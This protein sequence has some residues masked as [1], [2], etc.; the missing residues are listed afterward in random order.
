[1]KLDELE[2]NL[3]RAAQ[4]ELS[5]SA[6]DRERTRTEL[7]ARLGGGGSSGG[8][9]APLR[10]AGSVGSAAS[11]EAASGATGVGSSG[12]GSSRA[13]PWSS[14][15]LS[16]LERSPAVLS[17]VA[18]SARGSR[19]G[20][21]GLGLI[22][23]AMVGGW[24]GFGLGQSGWNAAREREAEREAA[25]SASG[26]NAAREREAE[27]EAAQSA[28]PAPPSAVIVG[29]R[30]VGGRV[31]SGPVALLATEEAPRDLTTDAVAAVLPGQSLAPP[32][33]DPNG[34]R[35]Q[36][37][38]P[39]GAQAARRKSAVDEPSSLAAEVAMLQ[40]ARRALNSENGR[41]A[42]GIVQD[43]DA[44]FPRGILIEERNATRVL[45]LCQLDRADEARQVAQAF[46]ERYPASVYAER[47]RGSCIAHAEE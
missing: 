3:I 46:L 37:S 40:R 1:V 45:S 43:L 31:A 15:A 7:F 21:L 10:S 19:L 17:R 18:A 29:G 11:S 36:G 8:S 41:L 47:V 4:R 23:G 28:L 38:T 34:G 16:N 14:A 5:P 13:A 42:L 20:M 27:R 24:F 2:R 12:V 9:G 22:V 30:V 39:R 32:R 26:W 35:A 25:Q 44:Q 6:N 33:L